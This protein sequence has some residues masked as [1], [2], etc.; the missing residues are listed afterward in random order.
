MLDPTTVLELGVVLVPRA[1]DRR[2]AA[3]GDAHCDPAA[4]SEAGPGV[5]RPFLA[6]AKGHL[7]DRGVADVGAAPIY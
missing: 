2:D 1:L 7:A 6:E 3:P 5:A 4:A